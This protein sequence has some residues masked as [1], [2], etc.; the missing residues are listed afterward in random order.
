MANVT[1]TGV[2]ENVSLNH[3]VVTSG[4]D[5]RYYYIALFF[6]IAK[7]SI[8]PIIL[9][10]NGLTVAIVTRSVTMKLPSYVLIA[11]LA[12]F[13]FLVGLV[14]WL[15]L[16]LLLSEKIFIGITYA[17]PLCLWKLIQVV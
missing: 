6:N 1:T 5:R 2:T 14:P 17:W 4:D 8:S 9:I 10:G 3:S 16:V 13:D 12:N 11:S 7:C 15:Q